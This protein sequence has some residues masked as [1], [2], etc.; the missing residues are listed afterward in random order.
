MQ[1]GAIALQNAVVSKHFPFNEEL[2]F[3]NQESSS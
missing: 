2:A 1:V 3:K